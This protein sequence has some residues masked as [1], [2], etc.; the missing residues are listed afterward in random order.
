MSLK[1]KAKTLAQIIIENCPFYHETCRY[2]TGYCQFKENGRFGLLWIKLEDV[3]QT[4]ADLKQKLQQL[5]NEFPSKV[6]GIFQVNW[7][8]GIYSTREIDEWKKKFE[9]LVKE[10]EE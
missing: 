1:E 6:S 7:R 2:C 9:E 10:V 8:A 5:L 3:E 4:L